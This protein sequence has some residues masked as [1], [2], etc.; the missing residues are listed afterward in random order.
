MTNFIL[1][2]SEKPKTYNSEHKVRGQLCCFGSNNKEDTGVLLNALLNL[3]DDSP[4]V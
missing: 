4:A 1:H 2:I 3:H